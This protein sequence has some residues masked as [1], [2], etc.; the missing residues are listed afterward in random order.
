MIYLKNTT[1]AQECYIPR[2][3]EIYGQGGGS[4]CGSYSEGYSDG[5]I[6]GFDSGSTTEKNRLSAI[7]ITQNT[8]IVKNRGGYSAITVNVPQTGGTDNLEY[9]TVVIN[10]D[11]TTVTPSSGYD[12]MSEVVVDASEY[13]QENYDNG[14]DDGFDDG[15]A[16]GST[17]EKSKLSA[18]TFTANTAVTISDGG[19]SAVTVNVD[20]GSTYQSGYTSGYTSGH[21]DGIEEQKSLLSSTAFTENGLY[22]RED[23]WNEVNVNLN[24]AA[25]WQE[26]YDSGF[27]DGSQGVIPDCE[28]AFNSGYASGVTDGENNIISTFSSMTATTNGIYGSS[29]HPLSSITVNVDTATT[30]QSG[31][32]SGHTDGV[33]EEKAKLSAT[34]F[35]ANTA[36]TVNQGGYSAVTVNVDTATTYN[37]GYTSGYTDGLN[38]YIVT[39]STAI[40]RNGIY[41][42]EK[43][44]SGVSVNVPKNI[45]TGKGYLVLG[46]YKTIGFDASLI[47]PNRKI[48]LDFKLMF[49]EQVDYN[50]TMLFSQYTSNRKQIDGG[51]FI[52]RRPTSFGVG[53]YYGLGIVKPTASGSTVSYTRIGQY[54]YTE[55]T[56]VTCSISY[57]TGGKMTANIGS[58]TITTTTP[59]PFSTNPGGS[60]FAINDASILGEG[61]LQFCDIA[62]KRLKVTDTRDN[63]NVLTIDFATQYSDYI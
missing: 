36:V 33:N 47:K 18:V 41:S 12:G 14:F 20:T 8:S 11:I 43:G 58:Q 30:Y 34:T 39:G 6:N 3:D 63:S 55:N 45:S 59:T 2:Q 50:K 57:I 24:T 48:E 60:L 27:T 38:D 9:K 40:T 13:G 32:T 26:G 44:W 10:S 53:Y 25:T 1:E 15:Y 49:G 37:S 31:Y 52:E 35:T 56:W 5:Y 42:N 46:K 16:S 29:S 21:T 61:L 19:Y 62:V 4:H 23:G 54:L 7:T 51:V 17:D 28:E 22:S